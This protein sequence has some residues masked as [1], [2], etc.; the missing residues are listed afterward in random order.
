MMVNLANILQEISKH[1]K[2]SSKIQLTEKIQND[3]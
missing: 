2:K 1:Y 3:C